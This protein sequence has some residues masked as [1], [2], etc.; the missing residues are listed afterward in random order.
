MRPGRR[1]LISAL[2]GALAALAMPTLARGQ[3]RQSP[4]LGILLRGGAQGLIVRHGAKI[5][6]ELA[7]RRGRP[8][9]LRFAESGG[10]GEVAQR[11]VTRLIDDGADVVISTCGEATTL[12]ALQVAERR[13]TPLII[14]CAGAPGLTDRGARMVV[15]SA[16][17]MSQLIGRGLGLMRDLH[18][19]A[20]LPLPQRLAL[21]HS[22]SPEGVVMRT[23]LSAVLPATNLPI[24]AYTEIALP[25]GPVQADDLLGILALLRAADADL[26]LVEAPPRAAAAMI[27]A[28]LADGVRPSGLVAFGLSGLASEAV[29]TLPHAAGENHITFAPWPEP[30]SPVTVEVRSL[31][32]RRNPPARF[33]LVQGELALTVDAVLLASEAMTRQPAARGPALAAALRATVLTQKMMRGPPMRFDARGQNTALPSVALQNQGGRPVVVLPQEGAEAPPIWPNPA[34]IKI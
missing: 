1:A 27:G 28:I 11:A 12:A 14:A 30:R 22:Q 17:T 9:A 21:V 32:A 33:E 20:A 15:R 4:R 19:A 18:A 8:L 5:A 29:L 25:T 2:T 3:A 24:E 6:A 16:P 13:E 31:F 23:T 34:L 26:V 10:D 7:N